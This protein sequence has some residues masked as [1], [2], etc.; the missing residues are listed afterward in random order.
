[1]TIPWKI[2]P[3][4]EKEVEETVSSLIS[5]SLKNKTPVALLVKKETFSP[6]KSAAA[7]TGNSAGGKPSSAKP[8]VASAA[9]HPN[10]LEPQDVLMSR[11]E[12]IEEIL[13]AIPSDGAVVGSTGFPSREIFEVREKLRQTHA[14][15]FLT[16]G[17]MGHATSI[18]LGI[19][20]G[21]PNQS[22]YCIEG[23]GSLLMHMGSLVTAGLR[24]P[25]NFRHIILNNG[26][27]DSVGAQPTGMLK[28]GIPQIA[29]GSG[30]RSAETVNSRKGLVDVLKTFSKKEGPALLEVI[31]KPGARKN[32]GRPTKST[33]EQVQ[34]FMNFLSANRNKGAKL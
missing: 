29:I 21:S 17:S 11:E 24:G 18:A 22:V 9:Y 14:S 5:H 32:L 26:V 12:A 6:Y 33:Q 16:V 15:D 30:Y 4:A 34:D 23:D 28:I 27:H 13:N 25:K 1:M 2:L 10:S 31:V 8:S 19:S 7:G 3:V 20:I